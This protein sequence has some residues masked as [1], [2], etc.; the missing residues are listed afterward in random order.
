MMRLI[1]GFLIKGMKPRASLL[2]I[3]QIHQDLRHIHRDMTQSEEA[4]RA[5]KMN[6]DP[7]KDIFK[8]VDLLEG[9]DDD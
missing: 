1:D 5:D 4:V 7:V 2:I 3:K 8:Y 6:C 9:I